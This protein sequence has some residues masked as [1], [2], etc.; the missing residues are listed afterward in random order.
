M[1]HLTLNQFAKANVSL[2]KTIPMTQKEQEQLKKLLLDKKVELE[3]E[4]N[5]IADKNPLIEGDY[6]A[7]YPKNADS[8][9]DN[10]GRAED[11]EVWERNRAV[12]QSLELELKE[13]NETI[14]KLEKNDYGLCSSC[15][16][17]IEPPRIKAMPTANL[18]FGCASKAS[19]I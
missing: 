11:T 9:D 5:K 6:K 13:I 12:E 3:V 7:R 17:P 15:K 4:L 19:L 14:D 16:S 10:V 1:L 8:S 18:C 2:L